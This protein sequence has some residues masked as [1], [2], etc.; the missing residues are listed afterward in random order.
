M[1]PDL[2]RLL[3]ALC[4][5]LTCPPAEKSHRAATFERLLQDTLDRQPG[6]S[7]DQLLDALQVR[8][9][10]IPRALMGDPKLSTPVRPVVETAARENRR[11]AG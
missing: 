8:Y 5:K 7:R 6:L 11:F 9:R 1:S 3:Q 4:E 10:D 2:E